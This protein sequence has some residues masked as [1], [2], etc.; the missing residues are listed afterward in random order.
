MAFR[1][2]PSDN[3]VMSATEMMDRKEF[4]EIIEGYRNV[5][6]LTNDELHSWLEELG[7]LDKLQP[8]DGEE[9]VRKELVRVINAEYTDEAIATLTEEDIISGFAI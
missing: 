3:E 7:A 2:E 4:N 6:G 1:K 5:P 8:A 9:A